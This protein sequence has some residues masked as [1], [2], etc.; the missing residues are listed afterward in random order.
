VESFALNY[1]PNPDCVVA[2]EKDLLQ[3]LDLGRCKYLYAWKLQRDLQSRLMTGQGPDTLLVC[4][5]DPV[6]T[7]GRSAK[8]ANLLVSLQQLQEQGVEYY[9]VE[10]GGDVTYH[11]PGQL[12]LYPVLNLN[13]KR[14]DVHWYMRSLEA[15]VI[16]TLAFFGISAARYSGRTGVWITLQPAPRKICSIGVRISRWCTMHGLALN[17]EDC[18]AGFALINPCGYT[19]IEITSLARELDCAGRGV[20]PD[21]MY[22]AKQRLVQN[23]LEIFS[24]QEA[25]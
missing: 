7:M 25:A 2:R 1:E 17:I 8:A 13:H 23:F 14:R 10:R 3:I 4:E 11:G 20:L 5:H 16:E 24:Y 15:V 6:I 22:Q 12:V 21:L 9:E 19:D 18:G